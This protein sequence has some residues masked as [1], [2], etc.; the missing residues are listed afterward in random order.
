MPERVVL[1][2]LS[3]QDL[4]HLAKDVVDGMDLQEDLQVKYMVEN[5]SS[6]VERMS[7]HD[8]AAHF[9]LRFLGRIWS[10]RKFT[11]FE[12]VPYYDMRHE[13]V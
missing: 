12:G 11:S 7:P 6:M 9:C 3:D 1:T 2:P 4:L 5:G 8:F 10:W 13:N